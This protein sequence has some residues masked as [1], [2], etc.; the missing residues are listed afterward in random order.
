MFTFFPKIFD[1]Y[2]IVFGF[3]LFFMETDGKSFFGDRSAIGN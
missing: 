1:F 3:V 2:V